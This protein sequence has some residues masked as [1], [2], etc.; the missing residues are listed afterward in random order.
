MG[1]PASIPVDPLLVPW[2][3][4]NPSVLFSRQFPSSR[5][6]H[7]GSNYQ[8]RYSLLESSGDLDPVPRDILERR[9]GQVDSD[10][11]VRFWRDDGPWNAQGVGFGNTVGSI[12]QIPTLPGYAA[13]HERSDRPHVTHGKYRGSTRTGVEADHSG[14]L[15]SDEGYGTQSRVTTSVLSADYPDQSQESHSL[16]GD[17]DGGPMQNDNVS[18]GYLHGASQETQSLPCDG[19][20]NDSREPSTVVS[21]KCE[22][23]DCDF[24]SKN[25]SD[26]R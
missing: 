26:H 8:E 2:H 22:R 21:L 14:R 9:T 5:N 12:N 23:L 24:V 16:A 19:C 17:T 3:H 1:P 11:L 7:V 18:R 6:S 10:P 15:I 20:S 13:S 4:S 25:Q